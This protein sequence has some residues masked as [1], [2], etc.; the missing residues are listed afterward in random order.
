M[1]LKSKSGYRGVSRNSRDL[2]RARVFVGKE[3]VIGYFNDEYTAALA[4]DKY[5]IDNN[6]NRRLNFPEPEPENLIPNTRLIRLTKGKFAVVD[7]EDFDKI[8]NMCFWQAKK[9][10]VGRWYA[11]GHRYENGIDTSIN[12]SRVIMGSPDADIDHI[13]GNGL[14][15]YKS[16]LRPCTVPQNMMN[17]SKGATK[18]YSSKYK[19]VIFS[20]GKYRARIKVGS[21]TFH[22]GYSNSEEEAAILYNNAA[23]RHF[24]KFAKVNII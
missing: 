15:N 9:D 24:G 18:V 16:N 7:E 1:K 21:K 17:K 20:Q 3:I 12:M 22:L 2:I 23:L 13:N 4:Y 19:G 5:V 14:H 11:C 8:N 10:K 6:L